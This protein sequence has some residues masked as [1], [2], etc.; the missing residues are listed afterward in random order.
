MKEM[1]E[2]FINILDEELVFALGCTEP[3]ALALAGAKCREVLGN[4][5]EH[6]TVRASGN[7]IKNVQGVIIPHSGGRR[8]IETAVILGSLVGN[9]DYGLKVLEYLTLGNLTKVDGIKEA[10]ICTVERKKTDAKLY[11]EIE[12]HYQDDYAIVELMHTHTNITKVIKNDVEI[13]HNPCSATDFNSS[14]T[15]REELSIER[16]YDFTKEVDYKRLIP[17]LEKQLTYN[18]KISKEGLDNDWGLNVGTAIMGCSSD[19]MISDKMRAGAAAGSDARMSGCDLPVVINSG[20]GNQGMTIGIP[21]QVYC[22][23]YNIDDERKYKALAMANLVPIHIKTSIGRLSAFCGAVTAAIGVGAA[24]TYLKDGSL[25]QVENTIKNS[26]ANLTGVICDGA[27]PSCA[28][29][30]AASLDAAFV[31]T[32]VSMN[33]NVVEAGTGI[34]KDSIEETITNMASIASD[35]MNETDEMIMDIMQKK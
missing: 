6:I 21:I 8:G 16:I 9:S 7:M 27:K 12:M 23:H 10:N 28:L 22:E 33:G 32:M 18:C 20:S 11:V 31:A 30:I 5:P 4:F 15:T 17:I 3:T 29:K 34:V 2:K 14:L 13:T 24:I 35:A 1:F 19:V 26:V 25:K